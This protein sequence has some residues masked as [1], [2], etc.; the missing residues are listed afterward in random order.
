MK[1]PK[2]R[3]KFKRLFV[4]IL[5]VIFAYL[6]FLLMMIIPT[7][8][9]FIFNNQLL[10]D[11]MIIDMANLNEYSPLF[12]TNLNQVEKKILENPYVKSVKIKRKNLSEIHIFIEENKP[13]LLIEYDQETVLSNGQRVGEV[14]N[15]PVLINYVPDY[16]FD[17]L[18]Q[19]MVQIDESILLK[20]SEIKYK[21]NDVDEERFLLYMI[22]G[23]YV[24]INIE[25]FSALNNYL[26]IMKNI[27]ETHGDKK[28]ILNLDAG[29]YFNV[30]K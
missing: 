26:I 25:K 4:L 23:N 6:G 5:L 7:K 15:V 14:F 20:I 27:I 16:V 24:Y 28:G 18:L 11:Q 13:I 2:K 22:D 29:E 3:F 9:I 19:K 12:K 10:S 17:Q 1:K 21:P 30:F 8:N